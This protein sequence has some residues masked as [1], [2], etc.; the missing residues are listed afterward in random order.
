MTTRD[1]LI[2]FIKD[3]EKENW[4]EPNR[5][6]HWTTVVRALIFLATKID[7]LK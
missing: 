4:G 5:C 7:E 3:E 2:E 6:I 1:E